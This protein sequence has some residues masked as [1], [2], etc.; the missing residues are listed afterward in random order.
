MVISLLFW[1]LKHYV[2][3]SAWTIFSW[4]QNGFQ[5]A[6]FAGSQGAQICCPTTGMTNSKLLSLCMCVSQCKCRK[7]GGSISCSLF[8]MCFSLLLYRWWL[9]QNQELVSEAWE[10][11]LS[12]LLDLWSLDGYCWLS[13]KKVW[14]HRS[15]DLRLKVTWA[16]GIKT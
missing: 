10:Q 3:F 1:M 2:C 16:E 6:S 7:E 9:V 11:H 14:D 4:S 8:L 15:V 12:K 13:V 5:F